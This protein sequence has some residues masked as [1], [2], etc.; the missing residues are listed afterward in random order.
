MEYHKQL[1]VEYDDGI[2]IVTD[3]YGD[4]HAVVTKVSAL[5]LISTSY[6]KQ[7]REKIRQ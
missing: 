5:E 6:D 7:L 4:I 1:D 3:V 2:L